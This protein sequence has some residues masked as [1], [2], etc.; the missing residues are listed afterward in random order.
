M[1]LGIRG[2]LGLRHAAHLGVRSRT[3]AARRQSAYTLDEA[4][5]RLATRK[6]RPLHLAELL[7][8]AGVRLRR[9]VDHDRQQERCVI[10]HVPCPADSEIPLAPEVSLLAHLRAGRDDR[11]E[12]LA[13]LDLPSDRYIPRLATAQLALVEPDL[14]P[15]LPQRI[16]DAAC[17]LSVLGRVAYEN[18]LR[19]KG[20]GAHR[21]R[22]QLCGFWLR[23]VLVASKAP[24]KKPSG[25]PPPLSCF[26]HP[27]RCARLNQG[28]TLGAWPRSV[29]APGSND[30]RGYGRGQ[31]PPVRIGHDLL[32]SFRRRSGEAA[33]AMSSCVP[34]Q[35]LNAHA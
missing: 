16:G 2:Y 27:L 11:H 26:P 12:Q 21:K 20:F 7:R 35:N 4:G 33:P 1:A 9:S 28:H 22:P 31:R 18:R 32:Q 29:E 14:D 15:A 25:M 23:S 8:Y 3:S 5:G 24:P 19:G 17:R 34:L 10:G 30:A 6:A 13:T